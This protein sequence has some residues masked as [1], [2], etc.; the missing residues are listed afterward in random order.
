MVNFP[1]KLVNALRPFDVVQSVSDLLEGQK[2]EAVKTLGAIEDNAVGLVRSVIR[3][4]TTAA[5]DAFGAVDA[6]VGDLEGKVVILLKYVYK[7]IMNK[8]ESQN[9]NEFKAFL[10]A[11][12]DGGLVTKV[13]AFPAMFISGKEMLVAFWDVSIG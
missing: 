13:Q 9:Y 10:L 2:D 12:S 4:F 5:K 6:K 11:L 8:C 7:A 3:V 1:E